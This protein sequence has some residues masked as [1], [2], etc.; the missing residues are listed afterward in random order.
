[1]E[2]RHLPIVKMVRRRDDG[3]DHVDLLFDYGVPSHRLARLADDLRVVEGL[4][5]LEVCD[6]RGGVE[7][8]RS[9]RV[10]RVSRSWSLLSCAALRRA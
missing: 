1:M 4:T 2:S 9:D 3:S 7:P 6:S 8:Q 10:D 5:A